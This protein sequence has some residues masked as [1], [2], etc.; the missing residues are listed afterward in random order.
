VRESHAGAMLGL[1]PLLIN[2]A[3]S[4]LLLRSRAGNNKKKSLNT[5]KHIKEHIKIFYNKDKKWH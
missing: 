5:R 3:R 4:P 2:I 1:Q